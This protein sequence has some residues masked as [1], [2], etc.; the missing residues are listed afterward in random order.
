MLRL[1]CALSLALTGALALPAPAQ[2]RPTESELPLGLVDARLLPGW[3]DEAGNRIAALE[4]VLKPGWKTYWRSPGDS[5]LPPSFSWDGS[6]NL[7]DV[8]FHWPAPEAIRSGDTQEL[9]YHD[10][11]VL[12]FTASPADATR[13]VTLHSQIE[14]GL[15]D[16]ICVPA[17]L[18]LSAPPPGTLPDSRIKAALA[19]TPRLV[20]HLPECRIE[21]IADGL[22]VEMALPS[23]AP[24]LAAI[25]VEGKPDLWVSGAQIEMRA[26]GPVAVAEMVGPEAAPFPLD[27]SALRLTVVSA[28]DAVESLGCRLSP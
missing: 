11:L 3:I 18:D 20:E 27:P 9:G 10:H 21:A 5:G 23:E 4:L 22:R 1:S 17:Q 12:P 25:E 7:R 13:P 16:N 26:D 19:E 14:L 8:V 6:E 15:C 28:K 2:M 24:E